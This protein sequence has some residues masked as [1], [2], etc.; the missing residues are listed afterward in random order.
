MKWSDTRE[1]QEIKLTGLNESD[2]MVRI[3]AS[4][5]MTSSLLA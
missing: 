5:K 4:E 3:A 1:I 2:T